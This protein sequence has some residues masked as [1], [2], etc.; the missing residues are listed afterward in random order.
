MPRA[1]CSNNPET[2]TSCC[3]GAGASG[4]VD[5]RIWYVEV[6]ELKLYFIHPPEGLKEN[7]KTDT[8]C[9]YEYVHA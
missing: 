9:M 7:K 1:P 6:C 3:V 8:A 5:T 2:G 4:E